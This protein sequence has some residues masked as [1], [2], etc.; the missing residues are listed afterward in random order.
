METGLYE[1]YEFE[2]NVKTL[3][4]ASKKLLGKKRKPVAD[5]FKA[6]SRFKPVSDE[7]IE[8]LQQETDARWAQYEAEQGD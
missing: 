5:Y 1:L 2:N 8:K 3:T 4:G 7:Q 6:Q